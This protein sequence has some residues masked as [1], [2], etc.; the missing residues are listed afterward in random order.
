M[1][2]LGLFLLLAICLQFMS[3]AQES[4]NHYKYV[5]VPT[6]YSFFDEADK[7]QINSLT[8]F[9][10]N[11][12]GYTAFFPDDKLPQE[13]EKNSCLA[14]Y[15][16]V[17]EFKALFKTKLRIDLDDCGGKLVMSSKV[18]ETREKQFDKA[19]NLALRDA[20]E[21]YQYADYKYEQDKMDSSEN[22]K[23]KPVENPVV[24]ET[25]VE[26]SNEEAKPMKEMKEEMGEATET[27]KAMMEEPEMKVKEDV[28]V[29]PKA[30]VEKPKME[31]KKTKVEFVKQDKNVLYAQPIK[32]GFQIV[33]T[34]PKI[35]MILLETAKS[36][37]FVVKDQNAIVYQEDGSWLISK[38][39]GTKVSVEAL[40]IKF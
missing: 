9:L 34:T 1:K 21:T 14:L 36:N 23:P 3:V 29:Q 2:K 25:V 7:Y 27:P 30:K 39:D 31:V 26:S 5:I 16:D 32:N 37:I 22:M 6:K 15:V 12:Y 28:V 33:D 40:N 19:Y 18:G 4:I 13:L 38:N 11:K 35:V 20:F 10:F 17:V 24:K 8:K